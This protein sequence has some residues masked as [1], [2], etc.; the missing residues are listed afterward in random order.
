[1]SW[2]WAIYIARRVGMGWYASLKASTTQMPTTPPSRGN[3]VGTECVVDDRVL[4]GICEPPRDKESEGRAM[5]DIDAGR[6]CLHKNTERKATGN[7]L[8]ILPKTH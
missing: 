1:M 2:M 5:E 8:S 6:W 7:H 4:A 3:P